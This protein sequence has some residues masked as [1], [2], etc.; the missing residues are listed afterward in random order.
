MIGLDSYHETE[1]QRNGAAENNGVTEYD[2]ATENNDTT[3]QRYNSGYN[4]IEYSRERWR[5][6]YE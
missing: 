2:G 5:N 4:K 6:F 1:Q 3:I